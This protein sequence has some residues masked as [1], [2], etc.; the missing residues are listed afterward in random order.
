MFWLVSLVWACPGP[1]LAVRLLLQQ[2]VTLAALDMAPA[3]ED[4]GGGRHLLDLGAQY[5]SRPQRRHSSFMQARLGAMPS[6]EY[7]YLAQLSLPD[8]LRLAAYVA[9][10]QGVSAIHLRAILDGAEELERLRS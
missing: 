7:P 8:R 1:G 2:E 3:F 5:A 4:G 10:D 6:D 9:G